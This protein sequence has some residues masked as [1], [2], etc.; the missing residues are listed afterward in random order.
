MSDRGA[1]TVVMAAATAI[2]IV[3]AVAVSAVANLYAARAAAQTAA[4]A[5]ALAA[6]VA[7][8]PPASNTTPARAAQEV[9]VSNGAA[10]VACRC[11]IDA[12]MRSRTVEV[13][14]GV[15]VDVPVFG[16][17]IV[18][19]VSRAEFDPILWLG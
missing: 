13:V 12:T 2:V 19:G 9:I 17:L 5:G 10:I 8:Y 11:P 4:D 6:A 7:T 3:L 16:R 14:A 1:M 15:A 18:E